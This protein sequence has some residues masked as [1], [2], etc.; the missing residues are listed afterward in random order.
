MNTL[1]S[2]R[3]Q[4]SIPWLAGLL[5]V[6][7][8]VAFLVAYLGNTGTSR[9]TALTKKPA[10]TYKTPPKVPL[11]KEARTVA[12]TFIN[13]AVARKNLAKSW[14]LVHPSLREGMTKADW[15]TGTIP[16]VPYPSVG[17]ARF[18]VDYSYPNYALIEVALLPKSSKVKPQVFFLELKSLK[19]HWLV[20]SWAPRGYFI[21]PS[22]LTE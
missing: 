5:L 3:V 1:R 10:E 16:V 15:L 14:P 8:V 11:S 7:G 22:S 21:K 17:Q 9:E 18:K 2:P 6:A 19:G 4:R 13:T 12:G 20:S